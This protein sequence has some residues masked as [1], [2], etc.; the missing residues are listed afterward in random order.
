MWNVYCGS[1]PG[2]AITSNVE[3]LA[4]S[5]SHVADEVYI[6]N[7]Q[8]ID[9]SHEAI[10]EQN[11]MYPAIYKRMSFEHEKELRALIMIFEGEGKPGLNAE[12]DLGKL[13]ES[14]YVSP[15]SPSWYSDLVQSVTAKFGFS[16]PVRQS[17]I[18]AAPF[19]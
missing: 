3:R 7:V 10:P 16:F 15:L 8:Y 2:I 1:A 14:V 4:E 9:Y 11:I 13:V 17:D 19:I 5:L 12:C 6:S 18:L